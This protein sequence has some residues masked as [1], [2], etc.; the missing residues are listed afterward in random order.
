MLG[1]LP[2]L[3]S[4]SGVLI[5]LLP[6]P[7]AA[8]RPNCVGV[9]YL[10]NW[11]QGLQGETEITFPTAATSW[12]LVLRFS[13]PIKALDFYEGEVERINNKKFRI[14]NK[15][16]NA[17][18]AKGAVMKSGWQARFKKRH[19]DPAPKILTAK[20]VD[21]RCK[22]TPIVLSTLTSTTIAAQSTTTSISSSTTAT[23]STTTA[24][25]SSSSEETNVGSGGGCIEFSHGH[26][27]N[28]GQDGQIS[29]TFPED[30]Q[31]WQVVLKFDNPVDNL[32]VYQAEVTRIDDS[33]FTVSNR[34]YNGVNAA[35]STLESGWQATFQDGSPARL[36]SAQFVGLSCGAST[37]TTAPTTS[38]TTPTSTTTAPSTFPPSTTT[39]T[40]QSTASTTTTSTPTTTTGSGGGGGS[41]A[42]SVGLEYTNSWDTGLQGVFKLQTQTEVTGWQLQVKFSGKYNH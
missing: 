3:L 15:N 38:T 33:S 27:W 42:C 26:S 1:L 28:Q 9:R 35:G 24:D 18:Q 17:V 34:N 4:V 19:S 39:T 5:N 22:A 14:T 7:A 23:T 41:A 12:A 36:A 10:H 16:Y 25:A 29:L 20:L 21:T 13:K 11:D 8:G 2:L 31:S 40:S 32:N 37:A 30:V 6:S